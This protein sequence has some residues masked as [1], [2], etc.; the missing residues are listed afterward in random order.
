MH[1]TSVLP[2]AMCPRRPIHRDC[3]DHCHRQSMHDPRSDCAAWHAHNACVAYVA[4]RSG[5]AHRNR[6]R[7]NRCVR[8]CP[9]WSIDW[10][11]KSSSPRRRI[12]STTSCLRNKNNTLS[13]IASRGLRRGHSPLTCGSKITN[14]GLIF[15]VRLPLSSGTSPPRYSKYRV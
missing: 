12:E 10:N 13:K 1:A 5:N 8:C 14:S 11:P 4:I 15:E 3:R 6:C 9:S 7:R 2:R